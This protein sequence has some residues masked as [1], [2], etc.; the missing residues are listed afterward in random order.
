MYTTLRDYMISI[1][2][3]VQTMGHPNYL[4]EKHFYLSINC[5]NSPALSLYKKPDDVV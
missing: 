4:L 2:H 3:A 5:S 1:S